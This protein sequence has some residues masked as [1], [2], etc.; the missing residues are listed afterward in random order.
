MDEFDLARMRE[1]F[2]T[3]DNASIAISSSTDPAIAMRAIKRFFGAWSKAD[4]KVPATFRQPDP[5]QQDIDIV[6]AANIEASEI[7]FA[8][9][10]SARNDRDFTAAEV[11]A[12]IL[13]ARMKNALGDAS[14]EHVEHLLP[15]SFVFRA[16]MPHGLTAAE[17]EKLHAKTAA[18]IAAPVTQ[19]EFTAARTE[20]ATARERKDR[21]EMWLDA[22][23][24]R[25]SLDEDSRTAAAVTLADVQRVAERLARSPFAAVAVMPEEI[26]AQ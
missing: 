4:K 1:R 18:L 21:M 13:D 10:G 6:R 20:I 7:R 5:P 9:R 26:S 23:T 16:R 3:A 2:F 25:F 17:K 22:D 15:G 11:L 19:A 8:A 14:V 24:Y 12:R